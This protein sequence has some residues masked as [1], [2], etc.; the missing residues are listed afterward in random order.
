MR[1]RYPAAILYI[2]APGPN[3]HETEKMFTTAKL[4]LFLLRPFI[5]FSFGVDI[6]NLGGE[7]KIWFSV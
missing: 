6:C 3:L 4:V 5:H 1:F 2:L 7:N